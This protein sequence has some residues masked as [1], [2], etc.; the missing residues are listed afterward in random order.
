[1]TRP[2]LRGLGG[3]VAAVLLT[4]LTALVAST[5]VGA[6]PAW[7]HAVLESSS[8]Y[9]G[10]RLALAPSEVRFTFDEAVTLPD[11]AT[12]VLADTGERVDGSTGLAD[13]GT[14]VVVALPPEVADGSYTASYRVVSA[15]GHVVSGSIRFGV[16]ADPS[17]VASLP[18]SSPTSLDVVHDASQGLVYLGAVLLVGAGAAVRLLWP[19]AGR[20]RRVRGLLVAG[21]VALAAGTLVRLATAGPLADSAGWAGVV[22][23]SGLDA[24]LREPG[25]LAGVARL[26]LLA[27]L[28]PWVGRTDRFG[29]VGRVLVPGLAVL[30]LASVALD[31]HAAAGADAPIAVLATTVHL[32]AMSFWLG[33]LLVLVVSVLAPASEVPPRLRR[34][35]LLAYVAVALLVLSGEYQAWRQVQPLDALS[36]TAYGQLLLVKLGL[37]AAALVLAALGRRL[38]T[39]TQ[40]LAG[41][42]LRA[43]VLVEAA[44]VLCALGVTTV[45]VATP[46]AR[47]TYGPA[48]T[49]AAPLHGGT[50]E[51]QVEPTRAGVQTLTIR[52]LGAD[53]T[54]VAATSV[55]AKLGSAAVAGIDVPLTRQPDGS[56][57]GRAPVPVAGEWTVTLTVSLG[58][59]V[60]YTT[61]ATYRTW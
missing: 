9:D 15:D 11:H 48:V 26:V 32:A 5:A 4:A 60:S 29:R 50:A 45:L 7:A 53:G 21:W 20:S 36:T 51:V 27:A 3:R 40:P 42:R 56:W 57:Q 52:T 61:A 12:S 49:L 22:R 19:D 2:R 31:G 47:T 6:T 30:L 1:M 34:W 43:G 14:T 18:A 58:S 39:R 55:T 23:L 13:G 24:T 35:S 59:D 33:G 54:P 25:G 41:G 37:V 10:Q 44:L 38:V 28:L 17:A 16:N 8:P 46:P